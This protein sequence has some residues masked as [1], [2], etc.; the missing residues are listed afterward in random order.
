MHHAAVFC[1]FLGGW[2]LQICAC[3]EEM[4]YSSSMRLHGTYFC[5][6]SSTWREAASCEG[7]PHWPHWKQNG[8]EHWW[9]DSWKWYCNS[10]Y[11]VTKC[12]QGKALQ[13]HWVPAARNKAGL[14][15]ISG[16]PVW[17]HGDLSRAG[18]WRSVICPCVTV[19]LINYCTQ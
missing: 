15:P 12:S 4:C 9:Q 18:R 13:K 5:S 11:W 19:A 3:S 6:W 8:Q 14:S 10:F 17:K 16:I 2:G 7:P 1:F